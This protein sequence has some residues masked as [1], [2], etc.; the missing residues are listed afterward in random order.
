MGGMEADG[1]SGVRDGVRGVIY[2]RGLSGREVGACYL[3]VGN[4]ERKAAGLENPLAYDTDMAVK[5][6]VEAVR[7][8]ILDAGKE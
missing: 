4:Q 1:L 8:L 2:R 7:Q 6:A 3:V 5:T